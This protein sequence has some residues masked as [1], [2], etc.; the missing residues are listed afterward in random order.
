MKKYLKTFCFAIACLLIIV[1]LTACGQIYNEV[2]EQTW[3]SQLTANKYSFTQSTEGQTV[4]EKYFVDGNK[5]YSYYS[6]NTATEARS[7]LETNGTETWSYRHNGQSWTK[8]T[9]PFAF[10][11]LTLKTLFTTLS[12][13]YSE[14]T[15]T[16]GWYTATNHTIN[17]GT[18][19]SVNLK[20]E[21]SKIKQIKLVDGSNLNI[22][23]FGNTNFSVHLPVV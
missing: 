12:L 5:A 1:P 3:T 13:E 17:G 6:N 15:L 23:E 16:D 19:D 22:I 9:S 20:F 10:N 21:N 18:Y 11:Y 4:S 8:T 2:T 7:Y 14:Y